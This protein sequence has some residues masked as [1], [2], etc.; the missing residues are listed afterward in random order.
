MF[1]DA[2]AFNQNLASWDVGSVIHVDGDN[3]PKSMEQMFN[4][5]GMSVANINASLR[6]WAKI[7]GYESDLKTAVK[8]GAK[9]FLGCYHGAVFKRYLQLDD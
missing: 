1:S 2:S 6:G 7:D 8:L 5:S 3:Q 9:N 4:G